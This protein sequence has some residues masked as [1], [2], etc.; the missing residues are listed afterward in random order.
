M[1]NRSSTV[2][3]WADREYV[4]R[5]VRRH[6]IAL[7]HAHASLKADREIVLA[8]VEQDD[9]ALFFADQSLLSNR[10]FLLEAVA[11][12]GDALFHAGSFKRDRDVV[13]AAVRKKGHSSLKHAHSSLRSDA[14]LRQIAD[15]QP[16][17]DHAR[18]IPSTAREAHVRGLQHLSEAALYTHHALQF[19]AAVRRCAAGADSPRPMLAIASPHRA[20]TP[21]AP[22]SPWSAP[23]AGA[24]R[25]LGEEFETGEPLVALQRDL[26][27]KNSAAAALRNLQTSD[28]LSEA[29]PSEA[30]P[31]EATPCEA[32]LHEAATGEAAGREASGNASAQDELLSHMDD[33]VDNGQLFPRG[34][35]PPSLNRYRH[36]VEE[37]R[38]QHRR[39]RSSTPT[40]RSVRSTPRRD[41]DGY[42]AT[43]D[44]NDDGSWLI[45]SSASINHVQDGMCRGV[46]GHTCELTL[47]DK[48]TVELKL[49][50]ETHVGELAED[51]TLRWDDG[52]VWRR[53]KPPLPAMSASDGAVEDHL[54]SNI[55]IMARAYKAR[56][57]AS[58]QSP[59]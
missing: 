27:I 7:Q 55:L 54:A 58:P 32:V 4:L 21:R 50:G 29:A 8:A 44:R 41:V 16:S 9:D 47:R 39:S 35:V 26:Q 40:Q 22:R 15:A 23:A 18:S 52:D 42:W 56:L 45:S 1:P 53:V 19:S 17:L 2:D 24:A 33:L 36:I 13:E 34:D 25:S 6:G 3:D 38:S 30:A 59:R 11:A 51:G 5:E 48:H 31:G 10:D 49:H 14:E 37:A 57:A 12:N 43:L 46:D 28:A 20:A